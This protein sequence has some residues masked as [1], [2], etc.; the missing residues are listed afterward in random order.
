MKKYYLYIFTG[1]S[2]SRYVTVS[3]GKKLTLDQI[4][5]LKS[6]VADVETCSEIRTF[7]IDYK[8]LELSGEELDA[9]FDDEANQN[10]YVMFPQND[11]EE[12]ETETYNGSD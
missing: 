10:V 6:D 3:V 5:N 12:D 7:G 2:G 4:F 8:Y 1:V 9:W 11:L